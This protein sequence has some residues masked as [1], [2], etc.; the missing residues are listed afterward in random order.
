MTC[1]AVFL[2]KVI[3]TA[4]LHSAT[5]V[6]KWKG[7]GFGSKGIGGPILERGS[8]IFQHCEWKFVF[9]IMYHAI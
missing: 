3:H 4:M 8:I 9:A 5:P 2:L 1:N 6:L 7:L